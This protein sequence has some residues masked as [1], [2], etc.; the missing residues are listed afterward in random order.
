MNLNL[1][2]RYKSENLVMVMMRIPEAVETQKDNNCDG[3][4][5]KIKSEKKS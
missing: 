1:D 4:I 3:N 5:I 2:V